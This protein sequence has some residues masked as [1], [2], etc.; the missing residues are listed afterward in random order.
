MLVKG[1]GLGSIRAVG[2]GVA[3]CACR[4]ALGPAVQAC[5]QPCIRRRALPPSF[6]AGPRRRRAARRAGR[7]PR[8]LR[9][10]AG[11]G[12]RQAARRRRRPRA[13]G[14]RVRRRAGPGAAGAVEA[15]RAAA[16][17]GDD[18]DGAQR[19]ADTL[20]GRHRRGAARASG[21]HPGER[22]A[23]GSKGGARALGLWLFGRWQA[24]RPH[25]VCVGLP[26][27]R[28]TR[29]SALVLLLAPNYTTLRVHI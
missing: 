2:C 4:N 13:R 3:C 22:G 27:P 14:A 11:R 7:R 23:C 12:R 5:L 10:E 8:G 1:G 26:T 18:A 6:P 28:S 29:A 20:A 24:L 19:D 15:L 9:P 17:R 25:V 16:A 21:G